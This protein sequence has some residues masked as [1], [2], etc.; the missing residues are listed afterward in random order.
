MSHSHKLLCRLRSLDSGCK[1]HHCA[2]IDALEDNEQLKENLAK[3]QDDLDQHDS[4]IAELSVHIEALVQESIESTAYKVASRGLTNLRERLV[5]LSLALSR[6][7]GAPEEG[8]LIEQHRDQVSDL[9]K[10]L[11]DTQQNIMSSCTSEETKALKTIV[12]D[13]DRSLFD[14]GV[15]LKMKCHVRTRW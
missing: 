3:E 6:L 14:I 13:I 7:S 1:V 10:E 2:V 9:K 4:D 12:I 15:T 8:P 11:Y 5:V